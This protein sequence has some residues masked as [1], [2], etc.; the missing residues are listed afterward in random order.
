MLKI[1]C[2]PCVSSLCLTLSTLLALAGLSA[3]ATST[4]SMYTQFVKPPSDARPFVRW[5]WNGGRV[6]EREILRELDVMN[7]A[8]IGGVEIN[9]IA[10]PEGATPQSLAQ[11]PA[12]EWLGDEWT[13]MVRAASD[14]AKARGMTADLIVGSG[15]PFGGRFLAVEEQTQRVLLVKREIIGP[16]VLDLSVDELGQA[17]MQSGRRSRDESAPSRRQLAMV[18]LL[19]TD[20]MAATFT[21]GHDLTPSVADGRIRINVPQG[22]HAIYA[23]FRDWGFTHVKLGAPGADGPVVN[24]FDAQAVRKYLDHMAAK[25]SPAFGG[26]LGNK[27]R[28]LFIDSLELDHANWADD[29]FAEFQQRRGYDLAPYLPFVLDADV[30]DADSA[31]FRTV[32]RARY[33][34]ARTLVELF[35]TRFV[36]TFVRFCEE[37]G[38]LARVQAYGRETHPLH[39]GMQVHLPEGETWLWHDEANQTRIKVESTSVNKYVSSAAHL[40][41]KARVS[42]EAMTN[43]VPVFRET[44]AN[45]KEGLDLSLLA[46]LNHPV[47]HGFNYTPLEAGFPGWVRF[48]CYL[49]ERTPWWPAFPRF[50]DY[51]ARLGTVLRASMAHAQV[52][53][54]APRADEWAR[55]GLLYQPF[56]EQRF[57]WY[58]Y[59]MA[60]AVQNVGYGS[61]FVSERI[62][63]NA[64]FAGGRIN[65]GPQ[66]YGLLVIQNAESLELPTVKAVLAYAKAGGRVLFVGQVPSHAPGLG[67]DLQNDGGVAQLIK[68]VMASD[69]VK[70]VPEPR[71]ADGLPGLVAW[72]Q[73]HLPPTGVTPAAVI[74]APVAHVSQIH[75]DSPSGDVFFFA[76]TST[77]QDAALKV[78]FPTTQGTPWRWDP[79]TGERT[80][81]PAGNPQA[82]PITLQP[83]QSL[84]L[85]FEKSAPRL[86]EG[87]VER[88]STAYPAPGEP[89]KL[90]PLTTLDGPWQASFHPANKGAPFARV[91]TKLLDLSK[92]SDDRDL[93]TFAGTVTYTQG[94]TLPATGPMVL[95]LG[96]VN[97]V[98]SVSVNGVDLGTQWYGHHRYNISPALK[99]GGNTV[100]ITVHTVLANMMKNMKDNASA[101]HWAFWFKPIP[102][103]LVGPVVLAQPQPL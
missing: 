51:A 13:K 89:I 76:N 59:S 34:F 10:M 88:L 44:L 18:R 49:N 69:H 22:R 97:S 16:R 21:A 46:G 98:S 99:V 20:A 11:S 38:V 31:F 60:S 66:S 78:A 28:A 29:L 33:D 14:G 41:G 8:G 61:D 93:A 58:Q 57:P 84:L 68:E 67:P 70:V 71:E 85:V 19:P 7:A 26:R 102:A 101:Q 79:Q 12:L 100:T 36:G 103:G 15:W 87:G 94:F 64:T 17:P 90:R 62:L 74:D 3:C 48:G 45:F 73:Q 83:Q 30:P 47:I 5:W 23:V 95:D 91:M 63:Q 32:R 52:A 55:L 2:P 80:P 65:F 4:D 50:S 56:P 27:L 72:S 81:Y 40:T 24:H 96:E 54:L 75:H 9:T 35:E 42:F 92:Q 77:E 53:I 43:A 37:Q 82:L 6:N 1:V 86:A 25:L 39:G